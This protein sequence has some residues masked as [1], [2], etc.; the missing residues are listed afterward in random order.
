MCT[1]R[2]RIAT[3][4]ACRFYYSLR[5]LKEACEEVDLFRDREVK[6]RRLSDG[7]DAELIQRDDRKK[8]GVCSG[9]REEDIDRRDDGEDAWGQFIIIDHDD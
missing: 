3:R 7:S 8:T 1:C 4:F 6:R 5:R 9:Y 2:C